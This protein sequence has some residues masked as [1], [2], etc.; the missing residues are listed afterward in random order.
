MASQ[1]ARLLR[2]GVLLCGQANS[3]HE[4]SHQQGLTG[5][6]L[7]WGHSAIGNLEVNLIIKFLRKFCKI[8]VA[9]SQSVNFPFMDL[10]CP[11][12]ALIFSSRCILVRSFRFARPSRE[13]KA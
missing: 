2:N 10:Y 9:C 4:K 11:L 6:A 8:Q 3:R 7:S 13:A 12:V 5:P 1:T